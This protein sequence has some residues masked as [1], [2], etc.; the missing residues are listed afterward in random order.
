MTATLSILHLNGKGLSVSNRIKDGPNLIVKK[1]NQSN[2]TYTLFRVIFI[3]WVQ[4]N[5]HSIHTLPLFILNGEEKII[6]EVEFKT[7]SEKDM[8]K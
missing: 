5:M 8:N 4:S 2:L 7:K 1:I 3:N 6:E